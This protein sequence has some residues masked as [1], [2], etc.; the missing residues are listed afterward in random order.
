MVHFDV[1]ETDTSS[2][3]QNILK[4]LL[5]KLSDYLRFKE[6]SEVFKFEGALKLNESMKDVSLKMN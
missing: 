4:I 3:S 1:E 5:F 6:L 2:E